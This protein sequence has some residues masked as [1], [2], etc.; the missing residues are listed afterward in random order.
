MLFNSWIFVLFALL[1]FGLWPVMR[2]GAN[3]RWIYLVVFSFVFY[4]WWDWRFL[5]LLVA[6]GIID[7]FAAL[8]MVRCAG[9]KRCWLA[10]SIA[11]NLGCLAIFKY[12]KFLAENLDALFAS[13]GISLELTAAIPE[14]CL[15]LPVGISFYTFQSMSYSID[16][17]RGEL[18]P[19]R[20]VFHFFAYLSLFPQLV[21]GPIVRAAD[22]LPQLERDQPVGESGRWEGLKLIVWGFFKKVLIADHLAE[23]VNEAFTN[24]AQGSTA[25]WW[26]VVT[27]FAFQIYGDF[28][29]YS[30]I[31]RG[32]ARWIGY[33]FG[34]NF[35]HPYLACGLRDFWQRWHISLS[36][37]FRDYVY[38]PLGGSRGGSVSAHT[39]MWITML[40]SGI[41]HGAAWTF[42]AWGAMHALYLSVERATDWPRRLEA[43]PLGRLLAWALMLAQV[44]I[45]W[46]FFRSSSFTD[47]VGICQTMLTYQPGGL[48]G[49]RLDWLFF[50]ALGIAVELAV[51]VAPRVSAAWQWPQR[52]RWILEPAC[53]ALM[54]AACIYLRGPGGAFIYFQ[55]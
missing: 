55:F 4:G 1:F 16:V 45:A 29:G 37:W 18:Q 52:N 3:R 6:S 46:V 25:Y 19:T 43:F 26:V 20:N 38:I 40:A 14:F 13:A 32:L 10:L 36:T 17:Y 54:I 34:P 30:D 23:G 2:H 51:A 50:L 22:L 47:A 27:M 39:Y 41:W 31:A 48:S 44:W 28:S 9:W 33:D 42:L 21:A 24:P 11:G 12:S 35:N 53:Y 5:F 49:L 8:A 15:I 7:F